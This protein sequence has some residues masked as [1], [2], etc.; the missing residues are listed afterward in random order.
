VPFLRME[1]D[2]SLA[3]T[4]GNLGQSLGQALDPARQLQAQ[5]LVDTIQRQRFDL[6]RQ[7]QLDAANANAA[8]VYGNANPH[9]LS[10]ADLEVAKSQIRNGT[11]NPAGAIEALKTAG[12]FGANQAAANL[13]DAT[14]P[15]WSE[16]QRNS[17][18][19]DILSGRKNLSEVESD[20]A[21]SRLSTAKTGAA[22]GA[23]DAASTAASQ[24]GAP[25]E[26]GPLARS[27]AFTD[28]KVAEALAATGRVFGAGNLG[29]GS[30]ANMFTD[31]NLS[32][33]TNALINN[34]QLAGMT[35]PQGQGP[36][37]A[38]TPQTKAVD[39]GAA[40]GATQA[41][42]RAP[43]QVVA[44]TTID[45]TTGAVTPTAPAAGG[46]PAPGQVTVQPVGPNT[47][48]ISASTTA[49]A[50][51][52]A[53]ADYAAAQLQ[54]GIS[55]G[56]AARKVANDVAQMRRLGDLMDNDGAMTQAENEIAS[57]AYAAIGLTLTP[58]QTAREVFDT[59][60][61]AVMASWRKDEGIQRLALP[62]IQL[63]NLSLPSAKMSHDAL[64]Q[65]LDNIQARAM[66]GD[67]VGQSALRY[68]SK[69]A[70]PE[71]AAAF[72]DE[73][74]TI[75]DPANNPTDTIR[76]E[77]V[78]GPPQAQP[79]PQPTIRVNPTTRAIERLGPDGRWGPM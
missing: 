44:P 53:A 32:A 21:N 60:K 49:E 69:G 61:S 13:I 41:A 40:I 31:P 59:Y 51:S 22:I 55:E 25:T 37:V 48:A 56:L 7:Q 6:Q 43:G 9:R 11:F 17:A 65:S 10:P 18:K 29:A 30:A 47:G 63:G 2:N 24:P 23:A 75:Y 72:L 12:T 3:E 45:L 39:T 8:E 35:R 73:R 1:T 4:L 70:T 77:R 26:L 5:S 34:Q 20:Y 15:D 74:N 28:P 66:L 54:D 42:P 52:K 76:K 50:S 58:G 57:R 71:N 68:W 19:A 62:E 36:T 33:A 64:N 46:T 67:K 14:H 16:G 27:A 79:Q 78:S 38:L